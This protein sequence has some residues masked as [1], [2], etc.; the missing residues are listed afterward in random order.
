[1]NDT[2]NQGRDDE[3][4]TESNATEQPSPTEQSSPHTPDSEGSQEVSPDPAAEN[5]PD[6]A[7]DETGTSEPKTSTDSASTEQPFHYDD[8]GVPAG[9]WETGTTSAPAEPAAT[10]DSVQPA[11]LPA[12][13]P[14]PTPPSKEDE[15][16]E[17]DGED[18]ELGARMTFLEHLDELRKRILYS[19]ISMAVGFAVCWMFREQIFAFIQYPILQ[20]LKKLV[21]T[22]P[23][24]A[25]TIYMKVAFVGG[26][27]VA[28]PVILMQIWMFIAP[29]L[30]RKEKRFVLPFLLSSTVL[31]LLGGAFAYYIVLPPALKF[32]ITDFG[33][34]FTPMITAE[35]YFDLVFIIIVGMGAVFQLP[36]LIAFLS[37]FGLISPRFLWKN[38]RYAFLLITIIAA[39]VSPTTDPFNLL[40]WTGPMVVLYLIGIVVSWVFKRRRAKKE[41]AEAAAG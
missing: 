35:D 23:T 8:E 38:F 32:L 10:D 9:E 17:D 36:V 28:A 41:A 29:G 13:P 19:I 11:E 16:D 25:F 14:P 33:A 27:F 18:K 3:T 4:A 21:V 30:Y 5:K 7:P 22:R 34:Q 20:V 6:P 40:L 2:T 12:P 15:A 39:V 37:M 24:E 26:I 31:F 1:M